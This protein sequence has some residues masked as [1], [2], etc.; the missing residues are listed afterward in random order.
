[1]VIRKGSPSDAILIRDMAHKI[2]PQTYNRILSKEQLNYML[3]LFY[4]EQTLKKEMEQGVEFIIVDDGPDTIGFASFS[5]IQPAVCKLHK[6]Y[7]LPSQQ[8]KGTGRFI[9]DEVIKTTKQKG[10]TTLQLNVNRHNNAKL[11]YE[12]LGFI[13]IREEDIDI[14]NGFFMNDYV[15][16]MKFEV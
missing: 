6:I 3:D 15:M 13:V 7:V 10:A 2:W 16:E 9:I 5:K 11:F 8:G 14:G 1:M 12:K 4:S